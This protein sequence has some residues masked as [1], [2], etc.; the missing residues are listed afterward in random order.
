MSVLISSWLA[1]AM[2]FGS[3]WLGASIVF[4]LGSLPVGSTL[5]FGGVPGPCSPAR[6]GSTA[7]TPITPINA[8]NKR[9]LDSGIVTSLK[10]LADEQL[11]LCAAPMTAKP[12][13][14]RFRRFFVLAQGWK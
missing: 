9:R 11:V 6:R 1:R 7:K 8:V 4:R 12:L 13:L 10:Q 5:A 14:A 3:S 2:A